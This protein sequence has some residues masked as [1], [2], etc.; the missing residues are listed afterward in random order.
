MTEH[1]FRQLVEE[2]AA[3][4]DAKNTLE[5]LFLLENAA[6][7]GST[8]ILKSYLGYC[9]AAE[10]RQFKKGAFLCSDA[11]K[12]EPGKAV[13]YLNLGRVYLAAGEKARAIKALRQGLKL[14]RNRY[15]LEELRRL[16]IRKQP[17]FSSLSRD[18]PL[19]KHVGTLFA[20]LG[21]R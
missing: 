3:A 11:L 14:G 2:G 16:G 8:P 21:M 6:L 18:H 10:Q 17:I 4:A 5:A 20:R 15:I 1:T 13:H 19:N 7:L 12:E 9:L